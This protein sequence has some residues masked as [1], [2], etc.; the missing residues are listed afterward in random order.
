MP[1][2]K[3]PI[4]PVWYPLMLAMGV[5]WMVIHEKLPFTHGWFWTECHYRR[6]YC[7]HDLMEGVEKPSIHH[8]YKMS[9]ILLWHLTLLKSSNLLPCK[10]NWE[11]FGRFLDWFC[12]VIGSKSSHFWELLGRC[13][14]ASL[15]CQCMVC[16]SLCQ[17]FPLPI[18][19]CLCSIEAKIEC[20][21][22]SP[23][24]S[25]IPDSR[26]R[27]TEMLSNVGAHTAI[28]FTPWMLYSFTV[29]AIT[30]PK[31]MLS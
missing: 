28:C 20:S 11:V 18:G 4:S 31:S 16:T 17:N 23:S 21:E 14:E 30:K 3:L 13:L 22:I 8:V 6:P 29:F 24:S 27:I 2:K 19:A 10:D 9:R 15:L 5:N 1:P 25:V 26:C 7:F 12:L